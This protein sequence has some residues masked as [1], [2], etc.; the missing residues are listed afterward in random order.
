MLQQVLCLVAVLSA[1]VLSVHADSDVVVLTTGNF[2]ESTT[3]GN[4]LVEFYA[5]WCGH[6][7]HLAPIW[8][9]LAT[10]LKEETHVGKVDCTVEKD[11]CSKFG[12]RGY[13]T[14]KYVSAG[15]FRDYSGKR[16]VEDFTAYAKAPTGEAKPVPA[17]FGGKTHEEL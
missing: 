12:I 17:D 2:K 11:I 5:P 8:E 6:C 14:I 9:S 16:T 13:P 3:E 4:W 10:A 15:E 7:K 1:L